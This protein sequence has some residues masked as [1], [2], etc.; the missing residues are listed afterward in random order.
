MIRKIITNIDERVETGPVQFNDDWPGLFIRGDECFCIL[1]VVDSV[2][3]GNKLTMI[4]KMILES[5]KEDLIN[6]RSYRERI[7]GR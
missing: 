3:K 7:N 5:I 4:E 6:T 2:L 1:T